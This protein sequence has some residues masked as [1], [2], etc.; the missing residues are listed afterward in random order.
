MVL[1]SSIA[2]DIQ[3]LPNF[4]SYCDHFAKPVFQ[5]FPSIHLLREKGQIQHVKLYSFFVRC[6][7]LSSQLICFSFN[8]IKFFS[9]L[10][11]LLLLFD[12]AQAPICYLIKNTFVDFCFCLFIKIYYLH[13]DILQLH[14]NPEF[15]LLR[16]LLNTT[17][18]D[19]PSFSPSK[20]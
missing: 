18:A 4:N 3:K 14:K 8:L 13:N 9:N 17:T 19:F 6:R 7:Y 12:F 5:Q 2:S 16:E 15:L 1:P 10:Y 11:L 20:N